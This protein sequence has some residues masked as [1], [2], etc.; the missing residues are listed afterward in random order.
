[1]AN[2]EG[3]NVHA[4][5]LRKAPLSINTLIAVKYDKKLL[6]ARKRDFTPCD[7]TPSEPLE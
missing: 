6:Y 7:G 1:M 2:N 3:A 5:Q 4:K